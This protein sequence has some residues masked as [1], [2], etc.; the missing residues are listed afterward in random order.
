VLSVDYRLAPEH[1]HPAAV[2]DAWVATQ[3]AVDRYG[4]VAV[5]GDSSG[6]HLA[7]VVARR[8]RDH[9]IELALQVLAVPVTDCR[10]DTGSHNDCGEGYGLTTTIVRWCFETYVPGLRGAD[11]PDVSPLRAADLTGLARALVLTA[12]YDPLRDEGEAYARRLAE[13]GVPVSHTRYNG[14]IHGFIRMS[15]VLDRSLEAVAQIA[16]EARAALTE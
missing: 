5:G 11:D 14:M 6:G 3:W 2:N 9:G 12:E 16:D 7:A 1:V 4:C 10:F 15:A 13:A 8:A